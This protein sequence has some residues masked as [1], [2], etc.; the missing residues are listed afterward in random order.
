[1]RTRVPYPSAAHGVAPYPT[2][3]AY[4]PTL[5][6]YQTARSTRV[7]VPSLPPA[8]QPLGSRVWGLG[9]RV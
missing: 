2:L 1:M 7:A 9:S 8:L 3:C 6:H 4:H 5:A